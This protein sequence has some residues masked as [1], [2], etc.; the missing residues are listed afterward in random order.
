MVEVKQGSGRLEAIQ[1]DVLGMMVYEDCSRI[2]ELLSEETKALYE[3]HA[4]MESFKGKRDSMLKIAHPEG[5]HPFICVAGL[6]PREKATLDDQRKAAATIA[7]ASAE[8]GL[9]TLVIAVPGASSKETSA[10]IVEGVLLGTYRFSK[11]KKPGEDERFCPLSSLTVFEGEEDG[12]KFGRILGEAQNYARDLINEPGNVITPEA[13]A[14][15]AMRLAEETDLFC[16]VWDEKMLAEKGMNAILAVGSGSVNPPRLIHLVW[17]P[18]KIARARMALV[19]KGLTFDSGGLDI[20]PSSY[21]RTMKGDKAGACAVFGAMKALAELEVDVEVHGLVAAV[22]NMPSGSAYR[23]DDIIRAYNGKTIEVEDT[24]AEGRVTLA[25]VLAYASELN[26]DRIVDLATLTGACVVALGNNM[27]GLF[28]NDEGIA[29]ALLHASEKTGERLWR[30]PLQDERLRK[31]I[32]SPVA[33]LLNAGGREGGA[34]TA[35]M[36]L[37]AFVK[38]GIPWAH[39]DIAGVDFTKEAY[40]YYPKGAM[41]FGV[42]TLVSFVCGF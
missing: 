17:R 40:G 14:E 42:R 23:P 27:A 35:A 36:F 2:L 33:D 31:S 10:A 41:G 8:K 13:L 28:A 24:D 30:L 6:G 25:D 4:K 16:E 19:G 29:E 38:E 3:K 22:E 15:E 12:L 18:K 39:L 20:K 32:D 26:P 34:I 11:Y 21:M 7:R 37:E 1:A 5:P 9:K